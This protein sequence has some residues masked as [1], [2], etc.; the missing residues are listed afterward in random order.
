MRL[1][2]NNIGGSWHLLSSCSFKLKE[3]HTSFWQT[4]CLKTRQ[5]WFGVKQPTFT[6]R[7]NRHWSHMAAD[8]YPSY[9]LLSPPC[10]PLIPPTRLRLQAQI[11]KQK[12]ALPAHRRSPN[13]T[14]ANCFFLS[15]LLTFFS[16]ASL[17]SDVAAPV[18]CA[19]FLH[20]QR[21]SVEDAGLSAAE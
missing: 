15:F 2:F 6:K 11:R 4:G 21:T 7:S 14:D 9:I 8:F 18:I 13:T 20:I 1:V 16:F 10:I 17:L 19:L 5:S 3:L 12:G